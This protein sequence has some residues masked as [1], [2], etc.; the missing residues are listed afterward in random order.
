MTSGNVSILPFKKHPR[1]ENCR[2]PGW[3]LEIGTG[4]NRERERYKLNPNERFPVCA[5]SEQN[6]TGTNPKQDNRVL[7]LREPST[8][9]GSSVWFPAFRCG[10]YFLPGA[11]LQGVAGDGGAGPGVCTKEEVQLPSDPDLRLKARSTGLGTSQIDSPKTL[12][13][14]RHQGVRGRDCTSAQSRAAERS[15]EAAL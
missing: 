6:V 7:E 12:Y 15:E 2:K 1:G 8:Q 14:G 10:N 3:G 9:R 13:A 4:R 11:H 5:S